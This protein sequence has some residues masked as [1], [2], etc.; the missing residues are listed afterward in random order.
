M[1]R[2]LIA[3]PWIATAIVWV[4]GAFT[5]KRT[6]RRQGGSYRWLEFCAL[7]VA[8]NLLFNRRLFQHGVLSTRWL[9]DCPAV[10]W[11]GLAIT[12]AGAAFA[13]AARFYIGRNWS[14]A[15]TLKQNHEL[16]RTGPYRLV[17]HPIYAGLILALTG[18][19]IAIGEVR[20]LIAVPPAIAAWRHKANTEERLMQQQF[21][22]GYERYR[23][24][25]KGLIPFVW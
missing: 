2:D 9:P 10:G 11:T 15:V 24:E 22:A 20:G 3:Y 19:A 7:F 6:V 23:R 21:G 5:S 18:T 14:S 12:T 1:N 4:L 25:V 8:Y 17:R 13:I 16:I